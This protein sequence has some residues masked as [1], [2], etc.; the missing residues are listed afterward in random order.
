M[1]ERGTPDLRPTQLVAGGLATASATVATSYL[2]VAGTIIGAAFMSVATTAG[3]AIYQYYFDRGKRRYVT[4]VTS[5]IRHRFP[6]RTPESAESVAAPGKPEKSDKLAA[7]PAAALTDEGSAGTARSDEKTEPK[8]SAAAA[9]DGAG[10]TRAEPR[11]P[12]WYVLAGAAFAIFAVVIGAITSV[13]SL[14]N[15]PVSAMLGRSDRSGTSLGETFGGGDGGAAPARH[16]VVPPS[17]TPTIP[18]STA[19]SA[20]SGGPSDGP[21]GG[22]SQPAT[23]PVPPP[24]SPSATAT[25]RPPAPTPTTRPTAP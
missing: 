21:S 17:T 25:T 6:G 16:P 22:H 5:G 4:V 14:T 1:S 24:V 20:P 3:A 11:R 18:S 19:S 9:P 7:S 13:E 8:E 15:K 2:G 12:R 23:A 10:G